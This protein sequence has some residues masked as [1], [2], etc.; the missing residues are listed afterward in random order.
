MAEAWVTLEWAW[1]ILELLILKPP[2]SDI[3]AAY[4]TWYLLIL[5]APTKKTGLCGIT[6]SI[7]DLRLWVAVGQVEGGYYFYIQEIT[8]VKG[9]IWSCYSDAGKQQRKAKHS[10]LSLT[11]VNLKF[12]KNCSDHWSRLLPS[13]SLLCSSEVRISGR[14]QSFVC[15]AHEFDAVVS[16]LRLLMMSRNRRKHF[17]LIITNTKRTRDDGGCK[18]FQHH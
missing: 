10:R 8:E 18:I 7:H 15:A 9:R 6:N 12:D 14:W 5:V 11:H 4:P 1:R 17:S 13:H 2:Y 16:R 3:I